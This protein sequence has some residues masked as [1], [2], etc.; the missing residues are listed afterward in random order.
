M[1]NPSEKLSDHENIKRLQNEL[2]NRIKRATAMPVPKSTSSM[3]SYL[4]VLGAK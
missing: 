2:E 3:P 1:L 4:G